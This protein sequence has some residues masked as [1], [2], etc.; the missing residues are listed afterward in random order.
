MTSEAHCRIPTVLGRHDAS[1]VVRL[2]ELTKTVRLSAVADCYDENPDIDERSTAFLNRLSDVHFLR[3]LAA[4]SSMADIDLRPLAGRVWK[5]LESQ[6]QTK[7]RNRPQH[8][9]GQ[10]ATKMELPGKI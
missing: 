7:V 6:I 9:W 5:H 8:D 3:R 4:E 1:K 2:A 10:R